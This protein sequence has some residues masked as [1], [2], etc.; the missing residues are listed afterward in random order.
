MAAA[1]RRI[2][3]AVLEFEEKSELVQAIERCDLV[4]L[5]KRGIVEYRVAKI[6]DGASHGQNH[7]ADVNNFRGAITNGVRP[8]QLERV[9]IEHQLQQSLLIS[10]HLPLGQLCIT[11]QTYFVVD[12]LAGE[13]LFRLPHHRNFQGWCKCHRE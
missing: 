5:G 12:V 13:L 1:V 4:C 10:E 3:T 2:V 9:R 11:S 8:E 7:L 6:F